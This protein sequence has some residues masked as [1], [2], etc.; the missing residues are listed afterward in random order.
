[1]SSTRLVTIHFGSIIFIIALLTGVCVSQTTHAQ[2]GLAGF[3]G[4]SMAHNESTSSNT[5]ERWGSH[6]IALQEN[7]ALKKQINQA[8]TIRTETTVSP[9]ASESLNDAVISLLSV[10][11]DGTFSSLKTFYLAQSSMVD[12]N[13]LWQEA[14]TLREIM[15]RTPTVTMSVTTAG[16]EIPPTNLVFMPYNPQA[17]KELGEI[18]TNRI[19]FDLINEIA[20]KS[21]KALQSQD[22]FISILSDDE[23]GKRMNLQMANVY[24]DMAK[25]TNFYKYIVPWELVSSELLTLEITTSA[26]LIA[27]P[28]EANNQILKGPQ[29]VNDSYFVPAKTAA[30][31]LKEQGS[32]TLAKL[33]M[34]IKPKG[35]NYFGPVTIVFFYEPPAN[36]WVVY[37][38]ICNSYV[39]ASVPF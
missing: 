11:S 4:A 25:P 31:I 26:T 2:T 15:G 16:R 30:Q 35:M 28:W 5:M 18:Y 9:D 24:A 1:M 17:E 21:Y 32:I 14:F 29:R 19:K 39:S 8:L 20:T 10:Y 7:P 33:V 36:K 34:A 3:L 23:L 13:A 12:S 37:Q 22:H 38:F 6:T 27:P